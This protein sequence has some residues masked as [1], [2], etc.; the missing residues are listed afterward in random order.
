[1]TTM[2]LH[3]SVDLGKPESGSC[4]SLRGE[5]RLERTLAYFRRHADARVAHLEL[6]SIRC[7]SRAKPKR[8]AAIHRIERVLH[9]IEQRLAQLA[10]DPT[11]HRHVREV[12]VEMDHAATR[13]FSA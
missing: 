6:H 13:A 2:P 11:N 12:A 5:E 10:G 9:E 8:S 1:M 3:N 4:A 7:D